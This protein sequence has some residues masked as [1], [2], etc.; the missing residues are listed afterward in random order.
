MKFL[1]YFNR[2]IFFPTENLSPCCAH[3]SEQLESLLDWLCF[4]SC[5]QPPLQ[6]IPKR[7]EDRSYLSSNYV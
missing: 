4:E 2:L 3:E 6:A 7:F 5:F 1:R